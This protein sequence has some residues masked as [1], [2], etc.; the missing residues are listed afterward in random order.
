MPKTPSKSLLFTVILMTAVPLLSLNMFLA[1]LGVMAAEFNIGYDTMAMAVSG[2]LVFTAFIQIIIGPIADRFGRRPVLLVSLGL[3]FMAS[4]GCAL[5]ESFTSFLIFRV[6][7]GAVATGSALS[8]AIVSDIVPPTQAASMLGYLSMAMSLAPIIGP[9]IGGGLAEVLGW[10]ANFWLYSAFGIG[11][12][13]LVWAR[14][15]ETGEKN[16]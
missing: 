6:L 4:C 8:R 7:Q 13:L 12:W 16:L 2:Y 5:V 10:R 15:P 3:F 1:S 14:L 9:T 11:L